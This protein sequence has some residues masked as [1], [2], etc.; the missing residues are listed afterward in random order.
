MFYENIDVPIRSS[1][2]Y[3]VALGLVLLLVGMGYSAYLY[4]KANSPVVTEGTTS[5]QQQP[6]ASCPSSSKTDV[7]QCMITKAGILVKS[8][9]SINPEEFEFCW[10]RPEGSI[11]ESKWLGPDLLQIKSKGGTFPLEYKWIRKSVLING[12]CP[13]R[14]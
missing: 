4:K 11:I 8:E 13:N 6:R 1:T 3:F 9:P 14:F 7:N 2:K 12:N 5:Q 10:V